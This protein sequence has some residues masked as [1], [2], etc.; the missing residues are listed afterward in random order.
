MSETQNEYT[1]RALE[2]RWQAAWRDAQAFVTNDHHPGDPFYILEMFPYPSGDLHMGH[3]RN[4]TIGDVFARYFRMQGRNVLHPMGWDSLGLPAEN[5]A[6]LEK[7]AP[8]VRTPKNIAR[9]KSQMEQLGLAYDW[10]REIATY[11]ADYYRWNQ[12]FFVKLL[13]KGLIYRRQSTVNWC[14]G[15]N[16]VL[17][18]EQVRD[19]ATCWRGHTGVVP[20]SVPEWAF[21]ITAYAEELLKDLDQLGA[22]PER[23]VTQQ[24]NWIGK[25]V[26]ARVQFAVQESSER[27]DIFTTR[28]DTIF[29][30]TYVVLAPEH[31]LTKKLTKPEHLSDV[32][33]FVERMRKTDRIARTA[34]GGVKEGVFTGSYAV[35][36]YTGASIPIWIANFVLAEYGTGAVMSVPAHDERDFA[37]AQKYALPVV[38]VVAESEAST[39]PVSTALSE[40]YT[41]DGVLIN[42]GAFSGL[43]SDTARQKIA[44]YAEA[45]GFGQAT[46]SWHLRDWGFSRQRYWG[47]PIPVIY[48]DDH[49]A[50]P[51]PVEQLPVVLPDFEDVELTGQGGAPLGKLPAFYETHCPTCKKPA[52]REVETMDTFVDSAWYFARYLSPHFEGGPF[53]LEAAKKWLPV[54]VYVGG[55]EHAVMHLLYFRFWT[56]AMRDIGLV[57]ID[58]PAKRLITQGMVNSQAYRCPTHGY[59]PAAAWRGKNSAEAV[60]SKCQSPL[61]VAVEKMSKSKYN[62][63]DPIEL[64]EKYGA[65]T[66]RLYTLFAA[67]PE[68]DLEWNPDGVEGLSR[69][70][71]RVYR[72]LVAQAP[73]FA[74]MSQSKNATLSDADDAVRRAAHRTL[75]KVTD[76]VGVRNHFN[77]A[78]AAM[79]E[80]VNTMYEYKLHEGDGVQSHVAQEALVFLA[81]MLAPFAP[82]IAE[83]MW[84]R[85]GGEGLVA[86]S[87]WPAFDPAALVHNRLTVAV[88][89][90]GK[91][92]GS[93]EVAA[94]ASEADV[95][96]AA[97]GDAGIARHLAE[98][99]IRKQVYVPGRLLNFVVAP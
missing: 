30:C 38:R 27:I 44:E 92:R 81:Q 93:I 87:R 6:I 4:Y 84:H 99:T 12:W 55:P 59:Q 28:V 91:L 8:Q 80:L 3:V 36:P 42:S 69:F 56:K 32:Q 85:C 9:M 66:A 20:R 48:C 17:A 46:V 86:Q 62:G 74:T 21:K 45:K 60:C 1:P 18:N 95:V 83:E 73:R 34:Q 39:S 22:W 58:E 76:E 50:V 23:I 15:C 72:L 63:V 70:V 35:N 75:A 14:P 71:T 54:D 57:D 90:N 26:G 7:V 79:M 52:R 97:H 61:S 24:R 10:T 37:F 19:D 11:K 64:I 82:H 94:E 31:P 98:K 68:K 77:T 88:Q 96:A 40:A 89:V 47:T 78:I 41:P 51:V 67:P 16:T 29:G 43:R 53:D 49:G 5:Q 25:S 65:D 2:A 13:E 33:A